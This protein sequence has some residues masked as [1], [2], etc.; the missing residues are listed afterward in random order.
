MR[1][2]LKEIVARLEWMSRTIL[3]AEATLPSISFCDLWTHSK[4][5]SQVSW[6][7][8]VKGL[9]SST[10]NCNEIIG[11]R[12]SNVDECINIMEDSPISNHE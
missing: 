7:E 3:L 1:V 9:F 10:N 6:I 12:S 2:E 5:D 8:S 4:I 11:A